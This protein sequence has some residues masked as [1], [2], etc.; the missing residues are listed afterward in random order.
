MNIVSGT[1][2]NFNAIA[3]VF[4]A[5]RRKGTIFTYGETIYV[6]G[7]PELN[8][9]LKA[10]E[11]VHMQRQRELGG[12]ESWWGRYLEDPAF[13]LQEELLAHRAEYRTAKNLT[14]YDTNRNARASLLHFIA[15]RLASPLYG[16]VVNVRE[17]K[18][19]ILA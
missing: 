5:A 4:P 8:P 11:A 14:P 3:A 10:H 6:N 13:R 18:R 17:A 9:Q 2:P 12:P 16:A 19:M 7:V 15:E 1:P